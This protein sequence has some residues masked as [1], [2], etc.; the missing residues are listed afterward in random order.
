MHEIKKGVNKFYIGESEE[1]AIAKI[2]YQ[3]AE[4]NCIIADGTYVSEELRGQGIA[5]LLLDKLVSF[6]RQENLK[7]IPVC[8]YVVV[9]F[10][11]NQEYQD[12]AQA[13]K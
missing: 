6:A 3:D 12:V 8:S 5:K 9:Q 2:T 7:I 13:Q 1:T 10:E 11:R 4:D